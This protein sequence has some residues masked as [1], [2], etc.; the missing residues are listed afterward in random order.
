MSAL[1]LTQL[2]QLYSI[3]RTLRLDAGDF[4]ASDD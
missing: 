2:E 1:P 3:L 4:A